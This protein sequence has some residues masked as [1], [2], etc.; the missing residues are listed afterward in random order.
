MYNLHF[1]HFLL[2][3]ETWDKTDDQKLGSPKPAKP[4]KGRTVT[5]DGSKAA[6]AGSRGV[7][8]PSRAVEVPVPQPLCQAAGCPGTGMAGR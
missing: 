4:S 1:L 7:L 3:L 2:L 8:S 6:S 5:A